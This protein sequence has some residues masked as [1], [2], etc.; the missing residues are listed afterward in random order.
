MKLWATFCYVLGCDLRLAYRHRSEVSAPLF[1]FVIVVSLFPLAISPEAHILQSQAQAVVWIA[2]LFGTLLGFNR[3]FYL[4]FLEG[5]LE[6]LLMSPYPLSSLVFAK[7]IAH[8]LVTAVPMI[9]ITPLLAFS[10]YLPIKSIL[11][12]ELSLL[13]GTPILSLIGA[14]GI[15]LTLGLR[16]GGMLL[17]LLVLPLYIPILI[18]GIGVANGGSQEW[19]APLTWLSAF[20]FL[21]LGLCPIVI[22]SALRMSVL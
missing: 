20:L 9:L 13:I 15:S 21:S 6:P 4:D 17:S 1:F 3:L 18:F 12:L 14:M 5:S 2:T 22:A 7:V 19:L 8:W 11:W 10:F 16:N